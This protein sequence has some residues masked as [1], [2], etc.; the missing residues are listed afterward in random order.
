LKA[1]LL[2]K[3]VIVATFL[4]SF[5]AARQLAAEQS[6]SSLST[7]TSSSLLCSRGLAITLWGAAFAFFS[8]M[9]DAWLA[10]KESLL[11]TGEDSLVICLNFLLRAPVLPFVGIGAIIDRM[12]TTLRFRQI[13]K[14]STGPERGS[15]ITSMSNK[16]RRFTDEMLV[17]YFG[18]HQPRGFLKRTKL[19]GNTFI[20]LIMSDSTKLPPTHIDEDLDVVMQDN[21]AYALIFEDKLT[22]NSCFVV[23]SRAG[24]LALLESSVLPNDKELEF[25]DSRSAIATIII[26]IQA[27]GYLSSVF[28]RTVSHL[29]VSPIETIGFFFSMLVSVRS[30]FHDV[31]VIHANP[32]V[33][34]LNPRQEEEMLEK[35]QIN[36]WSEADY[37]LC[38][39]VT[40]LV[41]GMMATML[42][43]FTVFVEWPVL[44][45]GWLNAI[46]PILFSLSLVTQFLTI[47]IRARTYSENITFLISVT[48]GWIMT[49]GGIVLSIV[50]LL[51]WQID[52]FDIKTPFVIHI[53]PF[54]G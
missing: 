9:D 45:I 3:G 1:V 21:I 37:K 42:M 46:G 28:Y 24:K 2:T 54:I 18:I 13:L 44:K 52:K 41:M 20:A 36:G 16:L 50:T 5:V 6:V 32:L 25:L 10:Y 49:F 14:S 15:D 8:L 31:G 39:N 34:Y 40:T 23:L 29:P 43:A 47:I 33:I 22:E 35:W 4:S 19:V 26:G 27:T 30:F 17:L 53:L 51:N 11:L 12:S 38:L 48:L 7:P